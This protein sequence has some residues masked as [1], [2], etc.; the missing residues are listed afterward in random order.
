MTLDFPHRIRK[1]FRRFA[2]CN[3]TSFIGLWFVNHF[4]THPFSLPMTVLS[5]GWLCMVIEQWEMTVDCDWFMHY[6]VLQYAII[7][8]IFLSRFDEAKWWMWYLKYKS[9]PPTSNCHTQTVL[10]IYV[11]TLFATRNYSFFCHKNNI[12]TFLLQWA[13]WLILNLYFE[14]PLTL[15]F[16]FFFSV[17]G[18]PTF[19][20]PYE[21]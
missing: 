8:G 15:L 18:V 12:F 11:A 6:S 19:T 3:F 5:S 1:L 14:Y 10:F 9:H 16:F 17:S 13:W 2:E 20:F 21:L 4:F 7:L